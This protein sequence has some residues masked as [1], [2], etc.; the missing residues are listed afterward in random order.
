MYI[1]VCMYVCVCLYRR[2]IYCESA[3]SK[4]VIG[5]TTRSIAGVFPR[6]PLLDADQGPRMTL[7]K[8]RPDSLWRSRNRRNHGT[9]AIHGVA[10][11]LKSPDSPNFCWFSPIARLK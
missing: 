9:M 1:Y 5:N 11:N 3:I 6:I 2:Y 10:G 4:Q 7:K 8:L